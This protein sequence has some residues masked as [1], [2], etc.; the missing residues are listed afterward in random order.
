V[1]E[2]GFTVT[3][4]RDPGC[5]EHVKTYILHV[6]YALFRLVHVDATN[7]RP[8]VNR[9]DGDALPLDNARARAQHAGQATNARG[10]VGVVRERAT[11][12]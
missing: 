10:R 8:I 2:I 12:H 9:P 7:L 11:V 3:S 5:F 4:G 6:P 1:A